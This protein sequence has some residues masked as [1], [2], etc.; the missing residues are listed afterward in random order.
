[1]RRRPSADL[2]LGVA[3][4]LLVILLSFARA[5]Q[6]QSAPPSTPSSYDA[7][8][9]G[10]RALYELLRREHLAVERFTFN[11][12][13]LSARIGT[14]IL[15]QSEFDILANRKAGISRN[16]VLS[17][18]QWV[19]GG[20]DLVVLAPP[21][22]S[23]E[24]TTLGIPASKQTRTEHE[25][26]PFTRIAFLRGVT[27]IGGSFSSAFA[28]DASQKMVPLLVTPQGLAAIEFTSGAGR[29]IVFTDPSI[30]SNA[31]LARDDNARFAVQ[32][33]STLRGPVA[34]DETVHGFGQQQSLWNALPPP[35]HLA[36]YLALFALALSIARNVWRF[37]PALV[38]QLQSERD[39]SAY[40]TSMANLLAHARASGKAMRDDAD[41]ALRAVR[42]ACG[43]SE[44]TKIVTLSSRLNDS[45][46]YEQV[47]ELD[48][49][50]DIQN[51]T[52]AELLRAGI[53]SSQLR[54]DFG[55]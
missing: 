27:Q 30:F 11:H 13:F 12:H 22:G 51:P 2:V 47:L 21:Y 53:L 35:V 3:A 34:F 42:R 8:R 25:A 17:L 43:V 4:L 37:A 7:G 50:R 48:R 28:L 5:T 31:A 26:L 33:L 6:Q 20:G 49:L 16:D 23:D 29:V 39:S 52:D 19:R 41:S 38:P 18:K 10:Y 36:V 55:L 24:D 40:I 1:M 45:Q 44:R 54:K 32:L 14:L 9:Y 46:K 15:A